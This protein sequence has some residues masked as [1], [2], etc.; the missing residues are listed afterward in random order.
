ME[1]EECNVKT[2][3]PM[4]TENRA[5]TLESKFPVVDSRGKFLLPPAELQDGWSTPV[6]ANPRQALR[7]LKRREMKRRLALSGRVKIFNR[8]EKKKAKVDIK[9]TTDDRNTS[10]ESV[11]AQQMSMEN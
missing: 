4:K 8:K 9:S 5:Q 7:I 6:Y 11:E 2:A 1:N 10:S 3:N